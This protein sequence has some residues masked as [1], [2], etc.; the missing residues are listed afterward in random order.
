[1]DFKYINIIKTLFPFI[2]QFK[3][4]FII[5][6]ISLSLEAMSAFFV[7]ISLAPIAEIFLDS[8]LKNPSFLTKIISEY[9]MLLNIK[10]TFWSFACVFIFG[11]FLKAGVDILTRYICLKIKYSLFTNLSQKNL[12]IIFNASWLFFGKS[13]RGTLMNSFQRELNNISDTFSQL[14]QQVAFCIQLLIYITIPL[15]INFTLTFAAISIAGVFM[16]PFLLLHK[17]S[18][19]LGKKNTESANIMTSRLYELFQSVRLIISH[20]K[21]NESIKEY[22][23][24]L[25]LHTN[26]AIKSQLFVSASGFLFQPFTIL[27]SLIAIGV[28][29]TFN[30]NLPEVAA[31][32]WGLMRAM[33]ILSK[34]LQSNLNI[35]N[36]IPSIT[37][38]NEISEK[39]ISTAHKNGHNKINFINKQIVLSNVSF[40]Y[41]K[42]A[43]N[44][45]NINLKIKA[46]ENTAIAGISG[47][48]KS[49]IIDLI[50]GIQQPNQGNILIDNISYKDINLNYFR[51]RIGYVPQDPQ[52]FNT[53]IR[54]NLVWFEKNIS[55]KKII[56]ACKTSNAME[57]I[58]KLPNRF[59]TIVGNS[60]T[61]LS[62]G[63]R[64]RLTIARA[65]LR[66]PTLLILDEATSS[67][68]LKS[69]K[70]IYDALKK[71]HGKMTIILISHREQTLK[72]ADK[73]YFLDGGTIIK[74]K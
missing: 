35:T 74:N 47:S 4:Y 59:D 65:L 40:I 23:K 14:A 22:Q 17:F 10:P 1:M 2:I 55:E 36:F 63:Q 70:L 21:Q 45:S 25:K 19:A 34:L 15:W 32:L 9:L 24:K 26:A 38:L 8:D 73:I 6:L 52:L 20:N 50:L 44:L 49:T 11:N 69:D 51:Q 37:Q 16:V 42:R 61:S 13:D 46:N 71:I 56:E 31:V 39:A 18:H 64:Q 58:N 3:K 43:F 12:K 72:Y 60:G 33:P 27:A 48:G 67:L 68:D 66:N 53:T 28:S 30:N 7:I 41:E 54:E 57:F 62:G 29:T 5:L